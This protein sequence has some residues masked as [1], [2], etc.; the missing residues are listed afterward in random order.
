M[1][2]GI[3][4]R[5]DEDADIQFQHYWLK[6]LCFSIVWAKGVCFYSQVGRKLLKSLKSSPKTTDTFN[7]A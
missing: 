4:N 6:M 5:Q 1:N 2:F 7:L 3:Y